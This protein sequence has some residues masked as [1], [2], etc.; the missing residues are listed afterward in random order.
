MQDPQTAVLI[1]K[2]HTKRKNNFKKRL[3]HTII[4]VIASI[5]VEHDVILVL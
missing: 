3:L 4:Y 1:G 5:R 2:I